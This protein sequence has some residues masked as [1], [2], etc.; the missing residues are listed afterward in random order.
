MAKAAHP[1]FQMENNYDYVMVLPWVLPKTRNK[2]CLFIP[3]LF[4]GDNDVAKPNIQ[5]RDK[6][7]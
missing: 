3:L 7:I 1:L 2:H 6:R 4:I 5:L